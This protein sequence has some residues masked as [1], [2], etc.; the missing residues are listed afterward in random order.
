MIE[1]H[2]G[3]IYRNHVEY[4]FSVNVN[5]L[6][7]PEGSVRAAQEAILHSTRYPD[8]RGEALCRAIAEAEG[9]EAEWILPGNGA[10]LC[11]DAAPKGTGEGRP[12]GP[13]PL[14]G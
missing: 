3:D 7:M 5:P 10:P 9:V 14:P 2:G 1:L 12:A 8:W 4:D 11:A 13:R 6:G